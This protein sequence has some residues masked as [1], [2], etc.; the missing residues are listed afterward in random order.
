MRRWLVLAVLA[1]CGD[2]APAAVSTEV[3]V[4][5]LPVESVSKL[6]VL[7]V[8]GDGVNVLDQQV[9]FREALPAWLAQLSIDGRPDLHV[10]AITTDMGT[11][12]AHGDPAPAIGGGPNTCADRGDDGAMVGWDPSHDV[13]V[14]GPDYANHPNPLLYDLAYAI[15]RGSNGCAWPQPLAA[16]RASFVN[17]TNVS[18][19]RADAALGIIILSDV[20]DCSAV[21]PS[22]FSSD[23]STLGRF[24]TFRCTQFGITCAE[25]DMISY[26]PRTQCEPSRASAVVEDP[27][28]FV[29]LVRGQAA[30][31]RRV[32]VGAIIAQSD[33]VIEPRAPTG[34]MTP[35]PALA[36]A[37]SWMEGNLSNTA[38]PALRLAW[39]VQ[40][41]GDRG[42]IGSICDGD[43]SPAMT[44]MGIGM[45]RAM[46]DPCVEDDVPLDH[47]TAVDEVDGADTPVP[48]CGVS[49]AS[50][51]EL[52]T[53]ETRCPNAAHQKLVVHR[54]GSAPAGTYTLLRCGS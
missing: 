38:N 25:P 10:A 33:I 13:V 37:C 35:V 2:N 7:F 47:C 22:L 19:R 53:D 14:D 16:L 3:E 30:D 8:I 20:D 17:P 49:S 40:Q 6:D 5:A 11:S 23:T 9:V 1:G 50:C 39:F 32:S 43:L 42:S 31:P 21:D 54:I 28:D 44:T 45:R 12:A 4:V 15:Q 46:G 26:G 52:V 41:F 48:P 27:A 18:F 24:S 29:D 34:T 36:H 51:W